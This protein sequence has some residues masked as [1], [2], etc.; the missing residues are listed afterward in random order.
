M[1]PV[2][3]DWAKG[4][5]IMS[6]GPWFAPELSLPT[7]FD[8]ARDRRALAKLHRDELA[9][10]ADEL[11]VDWYQMREAIQR[12]SREI[13]GLQCQ[14]ALEQQ[15]CTYGQNAP[16]DSHLEWARELCGQAEPQLHNIQRPSP[17]PLLAWLDRN[18]R[19]WHRQ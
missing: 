11:V 9:Q 13:A 7:Q 12:A 3:T 19:P 10:K 4:I 18:W 16:S 17:S 15:P 6:D 14:L 8:M 5:E 2:S 1:W